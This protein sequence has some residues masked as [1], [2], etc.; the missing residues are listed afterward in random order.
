LTELLW[1]ASSRAFS[2]VTSILLVKI[3]TNNMSFEQYANLTLGLT[4]F[5][6]LTQIVM[7]PIGQGV[8][9][10]YIVA[11]KNQNIASF[12]NTTLLIYRNIGLIYIA[13]TIAIAITPMGALSLNL[14]LFII[15]IIVYAYVFGIN[16]ILNSLLNLGKLRKHFAISIWIEQLI[17][18]LSIYFCAKYIIITP[19]DVV[20]AYTCGVMVALTYH[21]R[22][23]TN[24]LM[25]NIKHKRRNNE[26]HWKRRIGQIAMPASL[27]GIAVWVQQASDKWALQLFSTKQD[28][29]QFAAL[30][31][32]SYAPLV[33]GFGL[34]MTLV[35]P[36]IFGDSNYKMVIRKLVV[37]LSIGGVVTFFAAE[38]LADD[39]VRVVLGPKYADIAE[40]VPLMIASA[41]LFQAG[42]IFTQGL[43]R[44]FKTDEIMTTKLLSSFA[45]VGLNA[46]LAYSYGISGVVAASLI[47]GFIYFSLSYYFYARIS[48]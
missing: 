25:E 5:N 15:A 46:Y 24:V 44:K 7:A 38:S 16:D 10:V 39:I 32:I 8:G 37:L 33:M 21:K 22:V 43:L 29:A 45:S 13:A 30:Y 42:D 35:T 20:V 14:K 18:I 34:L 6:L 9:R 2:F 40:Y 17:K 4:L 31:Q 28:V 47:Y 41:C 3:L 27:W 48:R 11:K 1:I 36:I 12:K 23:S 26:S 19:I